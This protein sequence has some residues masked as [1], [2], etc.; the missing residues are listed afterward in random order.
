MR[1][2]PH[3]PSCTRGSVVEGERVLESMGFDAE[4]FLREQ[5]AADPASDPFEV[6]RLRGTEHLGQNFPGTSFDGA[7]RSI[8]ETPEVFGL[9]PA[10]LPYEVVSVNGVSFDFPEELEHRI[11]FIATTPEGVVVLGNSYP[12]SRLL[13]KR[14]ALSYGAAGPQDSGDSVRP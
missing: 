7:L 13:G 14:L 2:L 11:R 12:L 9:L 5:L 8:E 10:S 4:A 6:L 1:W 3:N